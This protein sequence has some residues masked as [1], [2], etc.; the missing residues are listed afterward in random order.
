MQARAL[1][2]QLRLLPC[3]QSEALCASDSC[4]GMQTPQF[5][6]EHEQPRSRAPDPV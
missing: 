1:F 6:A 2:S 3:Q 5:P 4:W